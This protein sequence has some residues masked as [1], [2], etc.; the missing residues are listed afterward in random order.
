MIKLHFLDH[1]KVKVQTCDLP[2]S[3]EAL[4]GDPEVEGRREPERDSHLAGTTRGESNAAVEASGV[5]SWNRGRAAWG[6]GISFGRRRAIA[7]R[8]VTSE[9]DCVVFPDKPE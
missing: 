7:P 5:P 2:L 9:P 4:P 3:S 1:P 8:A 6:R